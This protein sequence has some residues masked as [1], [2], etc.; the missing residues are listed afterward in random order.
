MRVSIVNQSQ[1]FLEVEGITIPQN[2]GGVFFN[3]FDKAVTKA[4]DAIT[5]ST[6][7]ARPTTMTAT[8][9]ARTSWY[10]GS[11]TFTVTLSEPDRQRT[12]GWQAFDPD[13]EH[14]DLAWQR[15]RLAGHQGLG[16]HHCAASQRYDRHR[17]RSRRHHH[18]RHG[19][20]KDPG[21][22][23]ARPAGHRP[24]AGQHLPW[25]RQSRQHLGR[26]R[27]Q[28]GHGRGRRHRGHDQDR[29]DLVLQ[30]R[31]GWQQQRR[32]GCA[33]RRRT[34]CGHGHIRQPDLADSRIRQSQWPDP[35][36]V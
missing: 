13:Q 19:Q 8:G 34:G 27:R 22:Q 15:T 11:T 35:E 3:G 18:Q 28:P 31:R 5:Q 36:R 23:N 25:R 17:G 10:I 29:R 4:G 7:R 14:L 6:A 2:N 26:R 21:G 30:P 33:A 32:R 9:P 12:G 20:R 16:R 1:H 24:A